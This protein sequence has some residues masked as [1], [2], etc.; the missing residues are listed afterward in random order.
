MMEIAE[1]L[2][3]DCGMVHDREIEM[4]VDVWLIATDT[5]TNVTQEV[6]HAV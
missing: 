1:V 6:S 4:E 2:C 5:C 3:P